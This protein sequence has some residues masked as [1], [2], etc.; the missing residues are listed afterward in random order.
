MSLVGL[1]RAKHAILVAKFLEQSGTNAERLA[2]RAHLPVDCLASP[3]MLVPTHCIR[4]FREVAARALGRPNIIL[5]ATRD[6]KLQQLGQFGSAIAQTRCLYQSLTEFCALANTESSSV[7]VTLKQE[8]DCIRLLHRPLDKRTNQW[9]SEL[10]ILTV[11]LWTARLSIPDWS[12]RSVTVCFAAT[13]DRRAA[14]LSLGCEGATFGAKHTSIT[15]PRSVLAMPL[16]VHQE[17]QVDPSSREQYLATRPRTSFSESLTQALHA[18]QQH[19]W[20]PIGVLAEIAGLSVRTLQ[21]RFGE[22]GL[23][24]SSFVERAQFDHAIQLLTTTDTTIGDIAAQLGYTKQANF[25][26][27]FQRWAGVTPREFRRQRTAS[28]AD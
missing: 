14:L 1:S 20:A 19:A 13:P 27:A 10:Y 22:E 11:M 16:Q 26:R 8:E 25:T 12:P 5:D 6:L 21:R 9:N 28:Q 23:T 18:Y 24:W 15:I 2:E 7:V 17:E 4:E 3:E